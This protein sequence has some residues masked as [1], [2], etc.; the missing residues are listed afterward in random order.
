[1]FLNPSRF[2]LWFLVTKKWA[3][4]ECKLQHKFRNWFD[5]DIEKIHR[6]GI[7]QRNKE[8]T[9]LQW[10]E[11]QISKRSVYFRSGN[12]GNNKHG[13]GNDTGKQRLSARIEETGTLWSEIPMGSDKNV[14]QTH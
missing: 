13:T 2:R 9:S 12:K 8:C 7:M 10:F 3:R 1:M 6:S 11:H 4:K 5:K 14:Q